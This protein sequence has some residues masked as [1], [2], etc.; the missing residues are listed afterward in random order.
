MTATEPPEVSSR[1]ETLTRCSVLSEA[2][3]LEAAKLASEAMSTLYDAVGDDVLSMLTDEFQV[4][5]SELG[6]AVALI[7][8]AVDGLV[9]SY[10][11]EEYQSRQ[12]V[13][14]HHALGNLGRE[15]GA[16]L[17]A[18]LRLLAA[19]IPQGGLKGEY[20]ARFAVRRDLRGSGTADRLMGLFV[21]DHP[22][23]SLHV[24]ADNARA[25]GFYHRHG[26]VPKTAGE[27]Q[28]M[29]RG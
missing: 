28:L 8:S 22:T 19:Q 26:F 25:I 23:V 11:A 9:A 15:A 20:V 5:G 6:D 24:R 7:D 12:R 16:R 1:L 21:A 3:R 17:I 27:F 10:P 29:Q 14:L 4:E 18:Q 13:S 2:Q